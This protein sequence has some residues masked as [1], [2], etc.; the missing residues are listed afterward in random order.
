MGVTSKRVKTNDRTPCQPS[1]APLDRGLNIDAAVNHAR[2]N[3]EDNAQLGY[4]VRRAARGGTIND[5]VAV[6]ISI[7]DDLRR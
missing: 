5:L 2:E 3:I 4:T 1:N 6:V 7:R